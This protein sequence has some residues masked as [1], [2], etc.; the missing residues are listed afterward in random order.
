MKQYKRQLD[1]SEE[2]ISREKSQ[3]RKIQRELEDMIEA[4]ETLNREYNNLRNRVR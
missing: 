2:E 1:E 4:H 3:K